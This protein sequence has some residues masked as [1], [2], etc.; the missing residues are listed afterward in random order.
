MTNHRPFMNAFHAFHVSQNSLVQISL[1]RQYIAPSLQDLEDQVVSA[2]AAINDVIHSRMPS[3]LSHCA[4]W[5]LAGA[6]VTGSALLAGVTMVTGGLLWS[7]LHNS[8]TN[9]D[10]SKLWIPIGMVGGVALLSTTA[11]P[12]IALLGL[13]HRTVREIADENADIVRQLESDL[14]DAFEA[15]ANA[16]SQASLV[17]F[18]RLL[19]RGTVPWPRLVVACKEDEEKISMLAQKMLTSGPPTPLLLQTDCCLD[20]CSAAG[21]VLLR[22]LDEPDVFI[23]WLEQSPEPADVLAVLCMARNA[24]LVSV[25]RSLETYLQLHPDVARDA[26]VRLQTRVESFGL[27]ALND[28]IRQRRLAGIA[29]AIARHAQPLEAQTVPV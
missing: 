13:A 14:E 29:L 2:L 18:E 3:S 8:M 24:M 5:L 23:D 6:F 11:I 19:Q 16:A 1:E 15:L 22:A 17:D 20:H 7:E 21:D 25:P 28:Q 4:Y 26:L 12:S 10:Q 27:H 9:Q